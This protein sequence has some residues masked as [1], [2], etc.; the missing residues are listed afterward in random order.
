MTSRQSDRPV[1]ALVQE[2]L[3]RRLEPWPENIT[4]LVCQDIENDL[5]WRSRYRQLIKQYG[6]HAVNSQIGR[7]TLA[8]TGLRNLGQRSKADSKLIK[9]FT[10][11]G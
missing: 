6:I 1:S 3:H 8:L 9:T 5:G 4:D 10:K 11:L 2:V 7:S